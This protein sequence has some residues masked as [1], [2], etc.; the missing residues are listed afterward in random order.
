MAYKEMIAIAVL[1]AKDHL[2]KVIRRTLRVFFSV[3]D[4]AYVDVPAQLAV[5][6]ALLNNAVAQYCFSGDND[7]PVSNMNITSAWVG[8]HASTELTHLGNFDYGELP[9]VPPKNVQLAKYP[10]KRVQRYRDLQNNVQYYT[11]PEP[12][13]VSENLQ[14]E[15]GVF[16]L[17]EE[18]DSLGDI[19]LFAD[20]K[21]IYM[22]NEA[23]GSYYVTAREEK[24]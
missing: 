24:I 19:K 20:E 14:N 5:G 2:G 21:Y 16:Q 9:N 18:V 4:A 10:R 1:Q 22:C 17:Y 23:V 12:T 6:Y 15:D 11:T 13:Y 8:F 7:V 3:D